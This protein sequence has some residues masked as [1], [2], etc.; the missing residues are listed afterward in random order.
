MTIV[1]KPTPTGTPVHTFTLP[2]VR[3]IPP[4]TTAA[5]PAGPAW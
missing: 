3:E 2:T 4:A 5:A 1:I